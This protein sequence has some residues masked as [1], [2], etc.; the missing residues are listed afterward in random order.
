MNPSREKNKGMYRRRK[1]DEKSSVGFLLCDPGWY[2][3]KPDV[4]NKRDDKTE[5]TH[6]HTHN[7]H[8][9]GVSGVY[10]VRNYLSRAYNG[11]IVFVK[12]FLP[13]RRKSSV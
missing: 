2:V 3:H 13:T 9:I 6:T 11:R 4:Q 10:L 5:N 8:I 1:V 7:T 12:P